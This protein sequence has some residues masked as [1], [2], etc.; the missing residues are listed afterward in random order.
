[1]GI[2]SRSAQTIDL[3]MWKIR[4]GVFAIP[5]IAGG[6]I[7]QMTCKPGSVLAKGDG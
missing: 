6:D 1:M 7:R 3:D 2:P 5:I 4:V